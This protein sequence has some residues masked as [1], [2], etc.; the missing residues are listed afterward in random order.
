LGGDPKN[1]LSFEFRFPQS[2]LMKPVSTYRGV[3][4]WEISPTTS[5]TYQRLYERLKDLPGVISAAGSSRPPFSG[6]MGMQFKIEGKPT[7]EPTAQGSNG[8]NVSYMPITPNYFATIKDSR[9]AR[10]GFHG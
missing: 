2:Q 1:L 8:M 7:P 5:L 10:P 9:C 4:L 6:S 3:G